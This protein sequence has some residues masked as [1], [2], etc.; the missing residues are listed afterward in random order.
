MLSCSKPEDNIFSVAWTM[1]PGNENLT[2]THKSYKDRLEFTND[3]LNVSITNLIKEDSGLY[4][5]AVKNTNKEVKRFI[6]LVVKE[7]CICK[8]MDTSKNQGDTKSYILYG[9]IVLQ[10]CIIFAFLVMTFRR[11]HAGSASGFQ[12]QVTGQ[13]DTEDLHYA[14][15][16]RRNMPSHPR[17]IQT[18]EQVTYAPIRRNN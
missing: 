17:V 6:M 5:C 9:V 12:T 1:F 7:P 4:C 2:S 16:L 10:T 14:E 13:F 18:E 8:D 11:P 3:N 15:I